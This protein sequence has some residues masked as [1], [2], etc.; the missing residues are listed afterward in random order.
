MRLRVSEVRWLKVEKDACPNMFRYILCYMMLR[1]QDKML[2]RKKKN[3]SWIRS[4]DDTLGVGPAH[5]TDEA[6]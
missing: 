2:D 6:G 1:R 3:K 4:T 5:S